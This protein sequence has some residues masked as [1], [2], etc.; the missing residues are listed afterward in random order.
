MKS[1]TLFAIFPIIFLLPLSV[2]AEDNLTPLKIEKQAEEYLSLVNTV[3]HHS[4]IVIKKVGVN[5]YTR[6]IAFT[7]NRFTAYNEHSTC[8]IVYG[9]MSY[10]QRKGSDADKIMITSISQD[11]TPCNPEKTG[12]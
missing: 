9:T 10:E 11:S 6:D 8:E 2:Q 5:T 12:K 3:E 1:D 7:F 4:A